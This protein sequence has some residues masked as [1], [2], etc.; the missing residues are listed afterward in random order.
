MI[1]YLLIQRK[2][3][4]SGKVLRIIRDISFNREYLEREKAVLARTDVD[5][6]TIEEICTEINS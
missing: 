2:M 6:Y 1:I 5:D 3:I 4:L